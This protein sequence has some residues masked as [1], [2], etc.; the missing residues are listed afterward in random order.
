[1]LEY[2]FSS[3][4]MKRFIMGKH[5][6][7]IM[8]YNVDYETAKK[9]CAIRATYLRHGRELRYFVMVADMKIGLAEASKEGK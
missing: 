4:V 6:V 3:L 9:T 8:K 5:E 7:S 2:I 1:M